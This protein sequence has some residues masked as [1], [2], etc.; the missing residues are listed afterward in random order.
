ML[1]SIEKAK[2]HMAIFAEKD[3]RIKGLILGAGGDTLGARTVRNR[4]SFSSLGK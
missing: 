1:Q 2:N 4:S 3:N